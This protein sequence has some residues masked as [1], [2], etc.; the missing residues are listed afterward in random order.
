MKKTLLIIIS[1]ITVMVSYSQSAK[2]NSS[3]S[4]YK[5]TGVV[6]PTINGKPY[7]QY[8]A[9]QDALKQQQAAKLIAQQKKVVP[10]DVENNGGTATTSAQKTKEPTQ[11]QTLER[12]TPQSHKFVDGPQNSTTAIKEVPAKPATKEGETER[13]DA[14]AAKTQVTPVKNNKD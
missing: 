4:D 2:T 7:S 8:K 12:G 11:E 14:G 1:L 10:V 6:D 5:T 13:G 9:E 3:S